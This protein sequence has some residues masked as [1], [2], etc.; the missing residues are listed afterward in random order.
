MLPN[1][2]SGIRTHEAYAVDLKSTP[3]DRSGILVIT[4]L[5]VVAAGFEPA[6]LLQFCR[7]IKLCRGFEPLPF[8]LLDMTTI[9]YSPNLYYQHN[10]NHLV[11]IAL[12]LI[13][14]ISVL[15]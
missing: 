13:I 6:K 10:L 4:V 9:S 2:S 5:P 11:I 3:F 14:W 15:P 12:L 7:I 1:T 8:D